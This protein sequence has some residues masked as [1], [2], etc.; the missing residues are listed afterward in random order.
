MLRWHFLTH[1]LIL[2][3]YGGERESGFIEAIS[4]KQIGHT[5]HARPVIR[6]G[7]SSRKLFAQ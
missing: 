2:G 5:I 3:R 6:A 7:M 4:E 1:A